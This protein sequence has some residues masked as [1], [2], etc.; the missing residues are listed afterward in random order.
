MSNF[1]KSALNG[2]LDSI[3][4]PLRVGKDVLHGDFGEAFAD[5]K[6][7][8]GNQ[9][10]ANSKTLGS[11]GINGWVGKHPTESVGA[12]VAT[13]FGGW[14]AWSAYGAGATGTAA[15]TTTGAL[16]SGTAAG[17]AMAY[18]PT[19]ST[20]LG[21]SGSA[22]TSSALAYGGSLSG[23]G[24]GWSGMSF[25]PAAGSAMAYSPTQSSV[26]G[27]TGSGGYSASWK[28]YAEQYLSNGS[29]QQQGQSQQAIP[30]RA[31]HH[32]SI[33]SSFMDYHKKI[34]VPNVEQTNNFNQSTTDIINNNKMSNAGFINQ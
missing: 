6:H 14:A 24:A 29:N 23:S 7:M 28:D 18:T 32:S 27:G 22:G 13:I 12:A 16:G 10:R 11:L 8:P 4:S 2:A 15:G 9:E 31:L 21:G 20:A 30:H 19:A 5:L 25:N 17:S 34:E 1:F 3:K 33:L 26:L